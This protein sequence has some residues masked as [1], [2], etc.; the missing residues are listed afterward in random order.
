MGLPMY[1]AEMIVSKINAS[2]PEL[3]TEI[4]KGENE[5]II[6]GK[7]YRFVASD[8]RFLADLVKGF[9]LTIGRSGAN[10]RMIIW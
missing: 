6:T 10:F 3:K 5:V 9:N 7:K 4:R 8:L 2:F 1:H